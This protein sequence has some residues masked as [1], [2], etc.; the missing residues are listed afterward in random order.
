[1]AR[2]AH[3]PDE[4]PVR[5]R[6]MREA[7]RLFA[8]QGFARTSTAEIVTAAGVTKPMLYYYFRDKDGIFQAVMQ[9]AYQGVD[10]ELEAIAARGLDAAGTLAAVAELVCELA[11]SDP[12]L[13]RMTLAATYGPRGDAP[14]VELN[15]RGFRLFDA[16]RKAATEGVAAGELAG[17]P[18]EIA[19]AVYGAI[20][21]H[22]M[23]YLVD[24]TAVPLPHGKGRD[25]T[26]LL[27]RGI[28]ARQ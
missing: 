10:A 3:R 26:D 15:R 13:A 20:E 4:A 25:V 22:V 6:L 24:A 12:D 27:L 23:G 18:V 2:K 16:F 9:A 14:A 19:M 17:D 1:M 7:T 21:M 28:R 11:R 5:E 8:Q